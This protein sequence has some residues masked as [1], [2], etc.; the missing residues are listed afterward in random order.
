MYGICLGGRMCFPK[1]FSMP[2]AEQHVLFFGGL[3]R[4]AIAWA[5]VCVYPRLSHSLFLEY[6]SRQR[7]F[8]VQHVGI[9]S[10]PEGLLQIRHTKSPSP[11]PAARAQKLSVFW[12]LVILLLSR[13]YATRA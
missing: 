10:L 12:S 1:S 7:L 4:G 9:K 3:V 2:V 5:Q 8:Y 6:A 13:M 11:P